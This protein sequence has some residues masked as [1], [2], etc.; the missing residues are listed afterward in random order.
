M[1]LPEF[2]GAEPCTEIGSEY[3]FP[4]EER[5]HQVDAARLRRVCGGCE[6]LRECQEYAIR[7]HVSGF[8]G[9]LTE[10]ERAR[11]RRRRKIRA[12]PISVGA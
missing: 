10:A 3:F 11:E 8:W 6:M 2:T 7:H 12:I 4:D 1:R 5:G 9:G